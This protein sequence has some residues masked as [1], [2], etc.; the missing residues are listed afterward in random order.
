MGFAKANACLVDL[1]STCTNTIVTI[2]GRHARTGCERRNQPVRKTTADLT[3]ASADFLEL[4]A[5]VSAQ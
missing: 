2:I 1:A 4:C 5:V 3:N